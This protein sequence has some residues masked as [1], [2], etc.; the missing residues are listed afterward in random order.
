M[1]DSPS[2]SALRVS[3]AKINA[4]RTKLIIDERLKRT[5]KAEIVRLAALKTTRE[6]HPSAS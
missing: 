6:R 1:A 3:D 2:S 5:S 4:A